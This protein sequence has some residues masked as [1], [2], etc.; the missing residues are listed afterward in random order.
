MQDGQ[1][2]MPPI[3]IG[4]P[5][6][7]NPTTKSPEYTP[8][9]QGYRPADIPMSGSLKTNPELYENVK[10]ANQSGW[11]NWWN[12]M[13]NSWNDTQIGVGAS[14]LMDGLVKKAKTQA[15]LNQLEADFTTGKLDQVSYL[16]QKSS[17]FDDLSAAYNSV[18]KARAS[19]YGDENDKEPVSKRFEY[20]SQLA[21]LKGAD[22]SLID[23]IKYQ[24]PTA[25]GSSF[26]LMGQSLMAGFGEKLIAGGVRGALAGSEVPGIGNALG[27]IAGIG[28]TLAVNL[29]TRNLESKSEVGSQ[30]L[31]DYDDLKSNYLKDK[32]YNYQ[33]SDQEDNDIILQASKGANTQYNKN[34][35]LALSDTLQSLIVAGGFNG[36]LSKFRNINKLTRLA[37]QLGELYVVKK[38]EGLEEGLQYA[39]Q[40]QKSLESLGLKNTQP[41]FGSLLQDY[42]SVVGSMSFL[43]LQGNG[44]YADDEQFQ[45]NVHSGELLGGLFGIGHTGLSIGKDIMGYRDATKE[46]AALN[47]TKVENAP[48]R[49]KDDLYAEFFKPKEKGVFGI[50]SQ[51]TDDRVFYFK[52]ALKNLGKQKNEQGERLLSK[53]EVN[54][55]LGAVDQAYDV[56]SNINKNLDA[57]LGP[58]DKETKKVTELQK[59]A[60]RTEL[61]HNTMSLIRLDDVVKKTQND[62]IKALSPLSDISQVEGRLS[63][64][65]ERL[66]NSLG[67]YKDFLTKEKS[68]LED[69]LATL[70][71]TYKTLDGKLSRTEPIDQSQYQAIHKY[72]DAAETQYD[73]KKKRE[74]LSKVKTWKA[75]KNWATGYQ[76]TAPESYLKD[77]ENELIKDNAEYAQ[78]IGNRADLST[79]TDEEK[80]A[81]DAQN[82]EILDRA[83]LTKS[84][85]D[86]LSQDELDKEANK[87][88]EDFNNKELK[89]TDASMLGIILDVESK[90]ELQNYL[91]RPS[92]RAAF[93]RLGFNV[94]DDLDTILDQATSKYQDLLDSERKNKVRIPRLEGLET[95][96]RDTIGQGRTKEANDSRET[97]NYYT[98]FGI[99]KDP[100]GDHASQKDVLNGIISSQ[101]SSEPEKELARKLLSITKDEQISFK[102]NWRPANNQA[103]TFDSKENSVRRPGTITLNNDGTYS[104]VI[105]LG[106]FGDEIQGNQFEDLA[107][108]FE[109]TVLHELT[110]AYTAQAIK[111]SPELRS[112]ID[113]LIAKGKERATNYYGFKNA[114]EFVAEAMT[115]P[116]FQKFLASIEGSG[117]RTLWQQFI[118]LV[119]RALKAAFNLEIKDTL[120]EDAIALSTGIID[121]NSKTKKINTLNVIDAFKAQFIQDLGKIDLN[122]KTAKEDLQS[123]YSSTL[124]K[125]NN[126]V[127][128]NELGEAVRNQLTS[129]LS[130]KANEIESKIDAAKEANKEV[131]FQG[132][133][134]KKGSYVAL[135]GYSEPYWILGTKGDI[136]QVRTPDNTTTLEITDVNTIEF[137]GAKAEVEAHIKG[138][139]EPDKAGYTEP[140]ELYKS[141]QQEF[142]K[143]NGQIVENSDPIVK[144]F[145]NFVNTLIGKNF[146]KLGYRGL[147]V[148]DDDQVAG[149]AIPRSEATKEIIGQ[150][151]KPGQI[152]VITDRDGNPVKIDGD[153]VVFNIELP[154]SILLRSTKALADSRSISYDQAEKLKQTVAKKIR[155][156]RESAAS[157]KPV[158]LDLTNAFKG[159]SSID[160]SKDIEVKD[161]TGNDANQVINVVNYLAK[162]DKNEKERRQTIKDFLFS[163][164]IGKTEGSKMSGGEVF[165]KG[166]KIAN[167]KIEQIQENFQYKKD[168][169]SIATNRPYDVLNVSE[170]KLVI[171]DRFS[172]YSDYLN[173][174]S[175]L[176][177]SITRNAYNAYL[178]YEIAEVKPAAKTII[179][180]EGQI[181]KDDN[182]FEGTLFDSSLNDN[183]IDQL[184]AQRVNF[185]NDKLA[186]GYKNAKFNK[187]NINAM[188]EQALDHPKVAIGLFGKE[189]V[190][191]LYN[192]AS[193]GQVKKAL[194]Y[195]ESISDTPEDYD[196]LIRLI[197]EKSQS[198]D[199]SIE[200]P[201]NN[202]LGLFDNKT[203]LDLVKSLDKG[204]HNYLRKTA[205]LSIAGA[206]EDRDFL[207]KA[208]EETRSNIITQL[209]RLE[210]A[211]KTQFEE[212]KFNKEYYEAQL[213]S[214]KDKIEKLR[215]N[216]NDI[217][218][219]YFKNSYVFSY[220]RNLADHY[221][222]QGNLVTE[223]DDRVAREK[224]F[225]K[226]GNEVS[227]IDG[228]SKEIKSMVRGLSKFK[229]V[230]D[231]WIRPA[232]SF[233]VPDLVNFAVT[234]NNLLKNLQGVSTFEEMLNK[235][236][237]LEPRF[238]EYKE[239]LDI[240]RPYYTKGKQGD[241]ESLLMIAKFHKDFINPEV[242]VIQNLISVGLDGSTFKVDESTRKNVKDLRKQAAD[243]FRYKS[244]YAVATS[245]GDKALS[246][247]ILNLPTVTKEDR[248]K[249]L[250]ALGFEIS[251][252]TSKDP[253]FD[254]VASQQVLRYI[255]D[256]IKAI[257]V[258][259][260][261][262]NPVE[263]LSRQ[264]TYNLGQTKRIN[265]LLALE[266]KYSQVVPTLSMQNVEDN[267]E[268]AISRPN[269]YTVVIKAINDVT[270]YPTFQDLVAEPQFSYLDK[271]YAKTSHILNSIFTLDSEKDYGKRRIINKKPISIQLTN[272]SGLAV[273]EGEGKKTTSLFIGDKLVTDI[274]QLLI[275]GFKELTRAGDKNSSF[276]LK[277]ST[278]IQSNGKTG[279]LPIADFNEFKGAN[280]YG[281][282]QFKGILRN[283]LK[284]EVARLIIGRQN[285][286]GDLIKMSD[287]RKGNLIKNVSLFHELLPDN[288]KTD[289]YTAIDALKDIEPNSKDL[290]NQADIIASDFISRKEVMPFI[291]GF[292]Y[293][294]VKN[295]IDQLA[296]YGFDFNDRFWLDKSLKDTDA[297]TILRSYIIN[298]F[299]LHTE[300]TKLF[301]G[302]VVFYST[303]DGEFHKRTPSNGATGLIPITDQWFV[304]ALNANPLT[305]LQAKNLGLNNKYSN[306]LKT[307]VFREHVPTSV[308]IDNWTKDLKARGLSKEQIDRIIEPY[309]ANKEADAQGWV[310]MD[311]YR[312]FK[313]SIGDWRLAQEKVYEK[314]SKGEALNNEDV[315]VLSTIFP[316]VKAQY[317][318]PVMYDNYHVPAF[319]KFSLMPLIPS[320]IKGTALESLNERMI[321]NNVSY[322]LMESGSKLGTIGTQLEPFYVDRSSRTM[323]DPTSKFDNENLIFTNFLKEQV[324]IEPEIH[325]EVIYGTQFRKLLF[326]NVYS[327]G[328][329]TNAK[330]AK[331]EQE[332]SGLID[333]ITNYE[334]QRLINDMGVS[335]IFKDGEVKDYEVKDQ[336]KFL[337]RIKEEIER[338]KLNNSIK[339]F[340]ELENGKLK[341][342]LDAS[343]NHQQV[344][345]LIL[346]MINNRLIRQTIK[347]D[348]LI[349]GSSLGYEKLVKP[350]DAQLL[351]YGTNGL[352]FY[353]VEGSKVRKMEVKTSL[354][355]DFKHLLNYNWNGEK[356]AT[357]ERL[358]KA[359]K[360]KAWVEENEKSITMIGY[361][362]PT[363]GLNSI[364]VMIVAEFLPAEAGPILI[365]P[366]EIVSK[367][368]SDFDIDKLNVFKPSLVTKNGEGSYIERTK[369]KG[370]KSQ[371]K[372]NINAEINTLKD[373]RRAYKL[374]SS[375]GEGEKE[376]FVA[377]LITKLEIKD[378]DLTQR[379]ANVGK[380][381]EE[382][383][384]QIDDAQ[385]TINNLN[386]ELRAGFNPDKYEEL[387]GERAA[388]MDL[389]I[390]LADDL[391]KVNG[392]KR[393]ILL[394]KFQQQDLSKAEDLLD[395]IYE[396][397]FDNDTN[398]NEKINDQIKDL[399]A[400]RIAQLDEVSN[401]KF[402]L[403]NKLIDVA[404]QRLTDPDSFSE[405]ITPNSTDL[406]KPKVQEIA[407][408]TGIDKKSYLHTNNL[409]SS[410]QEEKF[411]AG[412]PNKKALGIAAV[413]N[414]MSQLFN[415]VGLELNQYFKKREVFHPMV[416]DLS[417]GDKYLKDNN[418]KSEIESQMINAYVDVL[419]DDFISKANLSLDTAGA[420]FYLLH[421]GT[422]KDQLLDFFNHPVIKQY[423]TETQKGKSIIRKQNEIL[424]G[425]SEN[426]TKVQAGDD[427]IEDLDSYVSNKEKRSAYLNSTGV[428][429][430][431][432]LKNLRAQG[433]DFAKKDRGVFSSQNLSNQVGKNLSDIDSKEKQGILSYY[434]NVLQ[435]SSELLK[436]QQANNYDTTTSVNPVLNEFRESLKKELEDGGLFNTNDVTTPT[437]IKP[438]NQFALTSSLLDTLMPVTLNSSIRQQIVEI[439]SDLKAYDIDKLTRT[440]INDWVYYLAVNYG[441]TASDKNLGEYGK[442]LLIKGAADSRL[443]NTLLEF[444]LDDKWNNLRTDYPVV[445]SLRAD[446]DGAVGNISLYREDN[447]TEYQNS[448]I[449][450]F[451]ALA[452]FDDPTYSPEDQAKIS[453]FF[454]DLMLLGFIQSG[455]NKS[456]ISFSDLIPNEYYAPMMAKALENYKN[457]SEDR[458]KQAFLDFASKF[459]TNNP[460]IF[461]ERSKAIPYW[462][463]KDYSSNIGKAS[464]QI[465]DH[466]MS[467]KMPANQNLTGKDTTTVDL[468]EQGLRTATTRSYAL[469]KIGDTITFE[470]RPQQY[471]ITGIEQL[472]AE[473]VSDPNWIKQWSDKEQWTIDHFRNVL[474]GKTVHI[475]SWQ[476]SFERIDNL[477]DQALDTSLDYQIQDGSYD[478]L[479]QNLRDDGLIERVCK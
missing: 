27:A 266:S 461:G 411:L 44:I 373:K 378:T 447:S 131:N 380:V 418:L 32:P 2:Q 247:T 339:D 280:G 140:V 246:P 260:V 450:Q 219:Y 138:E 110:H 345:T 24:I 141:V 283:Y 94:N 358:N 96:R 479:I 196:H 82:K 97:N 432:S 319:H 415:K 350:T 208:L 440:F 403:F 231:S 252:E 34:M 12:T 62:S 129:Y 118:D 22:A 363:Q 197:D 191:I 306:V 9:D 277:F 217:R 431:E 355:G 220:S 237:Y 329:P 228:A 79:L 130:E 173:T 425:R 472:T 159:I 453:S 65:N 33:L 213:A 185:S 272:I 267:T 310:T 311:Y 149:F 291:R 89:V 455:L 212:G 314:L 276:G 385:D 402:G 299:I 224:G 87:A 421:M 152:V 322:A 83:G 437:V 11:T 225:D 80:K 235:L 413:A 457:L 387:V 122:S 338:R 241:M 377:G 103:N 182:L 296:K 101:Y 242:P 300:Q 259:K 374:F 135:K 26:S 47:P 95:N 256:E 41:F 176:G 15:K 142:E 393:D 331:L 313:I 21:N 179:P 359:L 221:D 285:K 120:L 341:Y 424:K 100:N 166:E 183:I 412:I 60:F 463:F 414:T 25:V 471:L 326:Q 430:T 205:I 422:P 353:H 201:F 458:Q 293:K 394:Q 105:D 383:K 409:T 456:P 63:V 189:A 340:F 382:R 268:Y 274:N 210:K 473:K 294:E 172:S 388:Q 107:P 325:N 123:L 164:V 258:I 290:Y 465:K 347:G 308:Y 333:E 59:S 288:T 20:N 255:K 343:I 307:V 200:N 91:S 304:D 470:G 119:A 165:I 389:K 406:L 36:F 170:G 102:E 320:A 64:V 155:E 88:L 346:S 121:K 206:L 391:D 398:Y 158:F 236:D 180:E 327:D 365:V 72:Y 199:T 234:W 177:G 115:S 77:Q 203:T 381:I 53:D 261:M 371:I 51:D 443:V 370:T 84:Y 312:S 52:E 109:A 429:S 188:I 248:V 207:N 1:F 222:E 147:L 282:E 153:Y 462:R 270:K 128:D 214:I 48:L 401:Y 175:N 133:T 420:F 460:S 216:F 328:K 243:N 264:T 321:R 356:I 334:V 464:T 419:N 302:D 169:N 218:S 459:R 376:E 449:E 454:K 444:K 273:E 73:Y 468:A 349:Q 439:I 86:T 74:G 215:N 386:A 448:I 298:E 364:E 14:D 369:F 23:Q 239:L 360:D 253:Q 404:S 3:T 251:D 43:G 108:S 13:V 98:Q 146:V 466:S 337:G 111:E 160:A 139:N 279:L 190:N 16:Q 408:K 362:I 434:L 49:F 477:S 392:I 379:L 61:F 162:L 75:L 426:L 281:G 354:T 71:D 38:L 28:S 396:K 330:L 428:Q 46:L 99:K 39:W 67:N 57:V 211:R 348:M 315:E 397:L 134:F 10:I 336:N 344:R 174:I 40:T 271:S 144:R 292:F 204:I 366:T 446:I 132:K 295:K 124:D 163:Y 400:K 226:I 250:Q 286:L 5:S 318:G 317:S 309:K 305:N 181:K 143:K 8:I 316:P 332:Y 435:E 254:I 423:V 324:Q 351:E 395:A 126:A 154:K 193:Y 368:G 416:N 7:A 112:E 410:T 17:L 436:L 249:F 289:L 240:L 106:H 469:G 287:P 262:K 31:Q 113:A 6:L 245:Q 244:K 230:G 352:R 58:R 478:A 18:N 35:S 117:N 452:G 151:K 269:G 136:L 178:S 145:Q 323:K 187:E 474:G 297:G 55:E 361:R 104:I 125:I 433:I 76:K 223:G 70:K 156:A 405:L 372:D 357:L 194:D 417:M 441:K 114:E 233:N 184:E 407:K 93:N 56:F 167:P 275:G 161:I 168:F 192:L 303:K 278:F 137:N 301:N 66:E 54:S 37:G 127:N 29:F 195:I 442:G 30:F 390:Y 475:G 399:I 45:S 367:A 467:Y 427:I 238:P 171:Q 265:D 438:F 90:D 263:D 92:I 150:G 186:S 148:Q 445:N 157:G 232:N 229:K 85:S 116:V 42:K 69:E 4:Q 19:I 257:Q 451:Q 68:N 202:D 227:P 476:T 335:P 342:P 198:F 375:L 209:E 284:G 81:R 384:Q 78:K 50:F